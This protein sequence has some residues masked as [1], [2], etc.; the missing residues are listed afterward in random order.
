[1][2]RATPELRA[3]GP[4]DQHTRLKP[5]DVENYMWAT[6]TLSLSLC[7]PRYNQQRPYE[8]RVQQQARPLSSRKKRKLQKKRERTLR[9]GRNR[10]KKLPARRERKTIYILLFYY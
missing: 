5:V 6:K 1:M 10:E 4:T 2:G 8:K 9:S 3:I 7:S